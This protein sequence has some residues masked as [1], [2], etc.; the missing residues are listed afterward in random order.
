MTSA[1]PRP[2]NA[3]SIESRSAVTDDR[4]PAPANFAPTSS[5]PVRSSAKARMFMGMHCTLLGCLD[6]R[7]LASKLDDQRVVHFAGLNLYRGTFTLNTRGR[8]GCTCALDGRIQR[9]PRRIL[10][11]FFHGRNQCL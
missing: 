10:P 6:H 11:A 7:P 4:I 9:H 3:V 5:A 1:R 2:R 8:A